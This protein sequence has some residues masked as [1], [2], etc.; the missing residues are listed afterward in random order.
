MVNC[1]YAPELLA[2]RLVSFEVVRNAGVNTL[3]WGL[4][5]TA[6]FSKLAVERSFDGV[7]FSVIYATADAA[8]SSY[9]D[10]TD[11]TAYYR[12]KVYNTAGGFFYSPVVVL[13]AVPAAGRFIVSP[14]P[15]FKILNVSVSTGR[16]LNTVFKLV[17][18]DG[19]VVF[20]TERE[21]KSGVNAFVFDITACGAG[22][23]YYGN[24]Q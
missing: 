15:F 11:V 18:P 24:E 19:K 12:V 3:R 17:S 1:C 14:S 7:N 8:V 5:D 10:F 21:L 16:K 4:A 2:V 6:D 9:A 23:V 20:R 22:N 13:K